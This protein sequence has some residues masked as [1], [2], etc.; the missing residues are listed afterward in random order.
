[1]SRQEHIDWR[2][3]HPKSVNPMA[4]VENP[5]AV[6]VEGG[7]KEADSSNIGATG[8]TDD[9]EPMSSAYEKNSKMFGM[10]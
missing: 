4:S 3:L 7:H 5:K 10:P 6:Q 8:Y 9:E 2:A 1:M